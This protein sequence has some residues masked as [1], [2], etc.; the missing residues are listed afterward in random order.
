MMGYTAGGAEYHTA[1]GIFRWPLE[2]AGLWMTTW[3]WRRHRS[4]GREGE[5]VHLELPAV[6]GQVRRQRLAIELE[7]ALSLQPLQL[8]GEAVSLAAAIEQLVEQR[9]VDTHVGG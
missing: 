9:G 7:I 2:L 3:R 1:R 5:T 8:C 4:N 6:V